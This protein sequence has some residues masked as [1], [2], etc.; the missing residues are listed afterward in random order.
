MPL[1]TNEQVQERRS[2]SEKVSQRIIEVM[3]QIEEILKRGTNPS[4]EL[5]DELKKLLLKDTKEEE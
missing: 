4:E 1:M 3:N 2:Y 5:I